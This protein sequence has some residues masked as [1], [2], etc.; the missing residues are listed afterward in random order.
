MPYYGGIWRN[1]LFI[2]ASTSCN[3]TNFFVHARKDP[4]FRSLGLPNEQ[5]PVFVLAHSFD[6]QSFIGKD[7]CENMFAKD[8]YKWNAFLTSE[9]R[10]SEFYRFGRP[11][12]WAHFN[13]VTEEKYN[14]EELYS[15]SNLLMEKTS[16]NKILLKQFAL[17]DEFFTQNID[18]PGN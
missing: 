8:I 13:T 11:L 2:V 17:S 4:S 6:I 5:I 9:F 7:I 1:I 18:F 12:I 14:N 3:V 15:N 10:I 16:V